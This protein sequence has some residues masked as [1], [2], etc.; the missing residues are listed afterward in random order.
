MLQDGLAG[1]DLY[2]VQN[3]QGGLL[4]SVRKREPQN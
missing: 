2:F 4:C 1:Y 3:W